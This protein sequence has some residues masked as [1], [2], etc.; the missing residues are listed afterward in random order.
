MRSDKE[1][2]M[3]RINWI[4]LTAFV[5]FHV[6][7]IWA[8]TFFSWQRLQLAG[9]VWAISLCPGIGVGWHRLL[10]HRG[11]RT[12][13]WVEYVLV[14]CGYLALQGGA[15]W[16]VAWH[17]IHHRFTEVSG[18]DPHTPRD[19]SWWAHTGWLIFQRAQLKQPNVLLKY[20]PDLCK[21]RFQVFLNRFAWMPVTVLGLLVWAMSD[22]VLMM[23]MVFVPVTIGW[24]CTWLVNSA[25][26]L[27]GSRAFETKDD[28]RNNWW[29]ALLTFGEGWH[30][31]HHAHPV[32]P[33]HG[34]RWYQVDPNW[35]LIWAMKV[36]RVA[37][38]VKLTS[39]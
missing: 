12:H 26:H 7:T 30:N 36:F 29:V 19:G 37:W 3:K 21:D 23:W 1:V 25:T 13:K 16:W 5:A 39:K 11:F 6:A 4:T 28:S 14:V 33:R 27:W 31:N 22:F 20:A 15:I 9:I 34:I 24:H 10:T 32:S 2:V 17:R 35:Y 8:L 38:E 18:E